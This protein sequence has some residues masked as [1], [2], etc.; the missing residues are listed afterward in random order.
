MRERLNNY[1]NELAAELHNIL[2]YWI[3]NTV[4]EEDGGF[5]GKIDNDNQLI[6]ESPKGSVLN[7]RILWSFSAAYNH[8]PNKKYL[9]LANR[10]YTYI[11]YYFIDAE[12]GG[13]YWSVDHLGN[14][15]DTKKQVYASAFTIYALSEF[16]KA[17]GLEDAKQQ[18][19]HLY[20]LL[21]D[22]SYDNLNTGYLEAFT[23]EWQPIKDLRLS[24]KDANEKKSMNTHL[25]V[26]EAYTALY[27]IWPDENLKS[28]IEILLNNFFDHIIDHKTNHLVLFFD[29]VWNKRSDTVSYGHDIEATWLL[30]EAAEAIHHEE[31]INKVKAVCIEISQVTLEGLDSDGGL[32]YEYET[33]SPHLIKEKHWW[34]Q[35]EAMVGFFNSWEIN[36]D[37]NWLQLSIANWQFVNQRILDKKNGEWFWGIYANGDVMRT[38][39]KAGLWKC[40]YHNSR[41]CLEIIKRINRTS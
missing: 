14:P 35:A 21:V 27:T 29:E 10:A 13:V 7:A 9:E 1:K 8:Q 17:T 20:Q 15:L 3:D 39:D 6:P 37:D 41:A 24:A 19:I 16:Y 2:N 33:T 18:A 25:H 28:Q 32:W 34:P 30:L 12:Y 38:E 40:P 11:T 26:L 36:G 23:R 22:K 5:Y 31:F 4:D